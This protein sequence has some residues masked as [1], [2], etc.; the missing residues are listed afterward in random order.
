MMRFLLVVFLIFASLAPA[1]SAELIETGNVRIGVDLNDADH[2]LGTVATL[3]GE[4][5]SLQLLA[6][7]FQWPTGERAHATARKE[8]L[9]RKPMVLRIGSRQRRD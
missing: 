7:N 1:S 6:N 5:D 2:P 8:R 4:L 9:T 3:D